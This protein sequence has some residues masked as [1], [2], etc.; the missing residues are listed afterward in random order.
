MIGERG[1][2]PQAGTNT[3]GWQA[4]PGECATWTKLIKAFAWTSSRGRRDPDEN[5]KQKRTFQS[6]VTQAWL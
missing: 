6:H 4:L 5:S 3:H 1:C 2:L